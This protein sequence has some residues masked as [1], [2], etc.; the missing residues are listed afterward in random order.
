MTCDESVRLL[1]QSIKD[2]S[3]KFGILLERLGNCPESAEGGS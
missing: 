1:A 3:A 2:L